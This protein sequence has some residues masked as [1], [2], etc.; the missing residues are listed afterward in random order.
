MD[1][2]RTA[3]ARGRAVDALAAADE[4]TR[5]FP[6]GRLAEEREALAIQALALS[7]ERAGALARAARFR[8]A[9]P[10]SI[11]GSAVDRAVLPFEEKRDAGP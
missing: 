9:Y 10:N 3:L 7:G 2:A 1:T 6:R 4:H 11:F 8:R 5:R